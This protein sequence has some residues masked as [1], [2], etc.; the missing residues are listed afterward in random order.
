MSLEDLQAA[1]KVA[2][3]KLSFVELANKYCKRVESVYSATFTH[4]CICPNPFHK[5]G[6]EKSPSFNFSEKD[7]FF[8]CFSCQISGDIF[9]FITL[10]E[11]VPWHDSVM[12]VIESGAIDLG[13]LGNPTPSIDIYNY[14]FHL[15]LDISNEIRDYLALLKD[16]D[17]YQEECAWADSVFKRVDETFAKLTDAPPDQA[18]AFQ[19]QILMELSRRSLIAS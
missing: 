16:S 19:T 17:K 11:G 14:L 2:A 10:V 12:Q 1:A 8:Y 18:K 13:E 5:N 7:K 6:N 3:S 9:D 4:K 15:N